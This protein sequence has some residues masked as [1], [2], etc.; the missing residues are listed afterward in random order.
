MGRAIVREP[1]AFLMDEP[2]SN[3]DAKLRVQMRAEISRLQRRLGVTTFYV[4]HDQTEAMTMGDRVAVLRAGRAAAVRHAAAA[5]RPAGRPLRRRVHRLSRDEPPPRRTRARGALGQARV[6]DSGAAGLGCARARP[7]LERREQSRR[8]RPA[9]QHLRINGSADEPGFFG[10]VDLVEP[11]G[12]E[13]LVHFGIDA[14]RVTT[15][16]GSW[17]NPSHSACR[18]RASPR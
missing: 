8:R 5:V 6:P 3:L 11:L 7:G 13:M 12:S 10:D 17:A 9:P 16:E 4:T 14:V 2:L 15:G 18:V 1:A